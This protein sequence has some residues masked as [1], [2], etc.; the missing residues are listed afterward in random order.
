MLG[1][2][3]DGQGR[4]KDNAGLIINGEKRDINGEPINPVSRANAK[5]FHR[6]RNIN[7]RRT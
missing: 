7:N 2:V 3:F 1:R 6:D 5:R 4:P